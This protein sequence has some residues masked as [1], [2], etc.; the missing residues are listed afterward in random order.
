M[1]VISALVMDDDDD[2]C[3]CVLTRG[4]SFSGNGLG[5][6]EV[7]TRNEVGR[8]GVRTDIER[9][10]RGSVYVDTQCV[11]GVCVCVCV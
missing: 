4:T 6:T 7:W 10:R 3:V 11:Y 2:V 9:S 1:C 8:W 5:F